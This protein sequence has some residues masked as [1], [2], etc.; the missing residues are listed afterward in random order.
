MCLFVPTIYDGKNA[1]T[2]I[3]MT[4]VHKA[5]IFPTPY[6]KASGLTAA[7]PKATAVPWTPV[8]HC[9]IHWAIP[10]AIEDDK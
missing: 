2:P 8:T 7:M 10:P 5:D 3:S 9:P 6:L 1:D 4:V